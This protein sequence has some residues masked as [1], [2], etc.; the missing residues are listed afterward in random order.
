MK[1]EIV[2]FDGFDEL[3]AIAPFE[4]LQ[5]AVQLAPESGWRVRLV[6][7]AE[8]RSVR[9]SHGLTIEPDGV[10]DESADLVIVPG[11][12]WNDRGEQGAWAQAQGGELPAALARMHSGGVRMASVCT[13]GMILAAAGI[14]RGRPAITHQAAVEDLRASGAQVVDERVVDDGD[15]IT[16]GGVTSGIDMALWLVERE[17]GADVADAVAAEMEHDRR[18]SVHRATPT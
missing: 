17:L 7:L 14:T 16:S 3:D 11:G 6:T 18:G 12:G 1:V 10:L 4:V 2:V 8:A 5:N 15:L 9:G 13:G